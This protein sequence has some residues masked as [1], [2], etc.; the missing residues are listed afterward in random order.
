MRADRRAGA[1]HERGGQDPQFLS[2]RLEHAHTGVPMR[3]AE[4]HHLQRRRRAGEFARQLKPGVHVGLG[5]VD[6][7]AV[8][9]DGRRQRR[10]HRLF[11]GVH[12]L[13]DQPGLCELLVR[14][15]G[16]GPDRRLRLCRLGAKLL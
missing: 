3:D 13:V 2:L 8:D 11:D 6:Q 4:A 16:I 1:C 9:R 5:N 7:L 14:L 10:L 12:G 15:E